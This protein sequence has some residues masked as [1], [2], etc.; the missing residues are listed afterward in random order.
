MTSVRFAERTV[1]VTGGSRGLGRA[2]ACAFAGEGAYVFVGYLRAEDEADR[3][4]SLLGGRGEPLRFDVT[5]PDQVRTAFAQVH[6]RRGRVD[7]LVNNAGSSRDAPAAILDP[8][9]WRE[10]LA[11]NLDGAFHCIQAVLAP[12]IHARRGSIINIASATAL[13]A[14]PGQANYAASK[15]GLLAMSRTLAAEL[16]PKGIRVN[17]VVPGLIDAGMVQHMDHRARER[18][19]ARIPIGRMGSAEEVAKAVLFLASDDASYLVG[20]ELRV[21]GGLTL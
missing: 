3:T 11:V 19:T 10:V 18:V 7:I 17:S 21:D 16:C 6:Q 20:C 5:R 15:G 1:V 13:R 14:S 8:A 12:M 2:M 4:V 9:E